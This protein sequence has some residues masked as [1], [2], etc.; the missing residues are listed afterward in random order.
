MPK[1]K[2]RYSRKGAR[3]QQGSEPGSTPTMAAGTDWYPSGKDK[4]YTM[5]I[6]KSE[7]VGLSSADKQIAWACKVGQCSYDSKGNPI[8][9]K[10]DSNGS[11]RWVLRN[12]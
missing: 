12:A 2:A 10:L 6:H 3:L 4:E 8:I 9:F 11:G 7:E 1:K 5:N